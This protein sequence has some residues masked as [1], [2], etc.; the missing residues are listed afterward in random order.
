MKDSCKAVILG[1]EHE[2]CGYDDNGNLV[3][4]SGERFNVSPLSVDSD[5][6]EAIRFVQCRS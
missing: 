4:A 5:A 1:E 3:L 2:V 6:L